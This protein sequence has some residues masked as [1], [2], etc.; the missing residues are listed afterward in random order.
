MKNNCVEFKEYNGDVY[1]LV[2]YKKKIKFVGYKKITAHIIFH[3]KL[4]EHFRRKAR[5]IAYGH[6]IGH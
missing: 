3:V 4:G 2:G 1:K 6:K 5:F